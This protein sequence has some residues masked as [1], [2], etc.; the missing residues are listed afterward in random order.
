MTGQNKRHSIVEALLNTFT[1]MIVGFTVSQ[2][3]HFYQPEIQHYIWSDFVWE[4][5]VKSNIIMTCILTCCSIVRGYIWR[6][7]FNRVQLKA[8]RRGHDK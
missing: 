1:G 3:A 4:L 8:Y 6:R 7:I 5:S 2:L